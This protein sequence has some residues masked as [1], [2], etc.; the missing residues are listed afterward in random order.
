LLGTY[1][2]LNVQ[3]IFGEASA[4]SA[5]D[6]HTFHIISNVGTT[7]KSKYS[8]YKTDKFHQF[9]LLNAE[10]L[11]NVISF[12]IDS[13][14]PHAAASWLTLP[15]EEALFALAYSSATILFLRLD[16]L[17]GL[18]HTSELKQDSIVPRFLSG[19]ATAFRSR[20]VE[21]QMAMSLVI[22]SYE[23]DTYLFAL[24]RE[25]NVRMWS[26]NKAQCIAVTD[27]AIE[28]RIMSQGAQGHILRKALGND[29]ELYLGVFL[30][31]NT[32]CEFSI[33][34]PMQDNGIFKFARLCTLYA[35][36][37]SINILLLYIMLR[38]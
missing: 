37:V 26:C 27:A 14:I 7:S 36:D 20:N 12:Y 25:G 13:P 30:K 2:D 24:C 5:R 16:T 35:P 6:P 10:Y 22:H 29:N 9:F 4:Q 11:F 31:F 15:Q 33:L 19:I 17:T 8:E 38:D 28:N 32:G 23:N 3:S 18:V 1:T 34:K 21:T